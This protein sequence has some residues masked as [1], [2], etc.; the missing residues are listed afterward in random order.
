MQCFLS[1]H[2]HVWFGTI[3]GSVIF[4]TAR[5]DTRLFCIFGFIFPKDESQH[6]IISLN[7]FRY[8]PKTVRQQ[9]E[10]INFFQLWECWNN[11]TV[12][13]RREWDLHS[14]RYSRSYRTWLHLLQQAALADPAV[15]VQWISVEPIFIVGG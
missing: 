5:P 3:K 1:I 8:F 10:R 2:R 11:E 4:G 6:T 14:W 15:I 13:T 12:C 7:Y 9:C